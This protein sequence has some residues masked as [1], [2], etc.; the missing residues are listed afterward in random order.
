MPSL[1]ADDIDR[2]CIIL[3]GLGGMPE[4]EENFQSW[5]DQIEH[6]FSEDHA[7]KVVRLNGRQQ[8]KSDILASLQNTGGEI[9][10]SGEVWL[11]LIGHGSFD[12]R[13]Y[14][15]NIKGPDL[16]GEDLALLLSSWGE[17]RL[18]LVAGTSA[19]GG[20]VDELGGTGRVVLAAARQR[21]RQPPLFM[22]FFAEGIQSAE[23][24]TNK[25]GRVSLKEAFEFSEER[26]K[27]WYEEKGRIQTEHAQLNDETL[28]TLA[29]VAR[30]PAREYE[31]LEAQNLAAQKREVEREIE[32]LKLRKGQMAEEQYYG[33]LETLLIKL[34]DLNQR[35][36]KLEESS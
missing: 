23:A 25:D 30:P 14:K 34:A 33:E 4:Y 32:D 15:F 27:T 11:F 9:A 1:L 7:T 31:S 36:N 6:V 8:R 20:L 2:V 10:S 28:S 18:F 13:T 29:Y 35:L 22:S 16:T 3:T 5:A 26:V 17:P 12:G 21:E 24:D 19:S